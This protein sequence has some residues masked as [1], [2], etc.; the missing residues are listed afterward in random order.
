MYTREYRKFAPHLT[1]ARWGIVAAMAMMS[2]TL[3]A[4]PATAWQ[5]T[6]PISKTKQLQQATA[7]LKAMADSLRGAVVP[8]NASMCP[9]GWEPY[10]PAQGRFVR[11]INQ[12][13]DRS[14]D[15]DGVRAPGS[16]QADELKSHTHTHI[17]MVY[18]NNVDGVDSVVTHSGE[19]HNE[20]R[21]TGATG[22]AETRP[23]NVALLYCERR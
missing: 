17:Q 3:A 15:P 19:H 1:A 6:A 2:S 23:K 18:D 16:V 22:A 4:G 20:Q 21:D 5:G 7:D 14:I 13:G 12:T 10:G 8:F 11:G 9:A